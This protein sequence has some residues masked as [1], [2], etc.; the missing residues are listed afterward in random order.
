M[1]F[2]NRIQGEEA[3]ASRDHRAR[4]E[5]CRDQIKAVSPGAPTTRT[6]AGGLEP[7]SR[8]AHEPRPEDGDEASARDRELAAAH[9]AAAMRELARHLRLPAETELDIEVDS[10]SRQVRFL[11]RDRSTGE[12]VRSVPP[13]EAARLADRL[14]E[15]TGVLVDRAL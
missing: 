6:Q 13:E 9:R 1:H 11:I 12:V 7:V 4:A 8:P 15:F 3:P 5:P 14:R 10:E 2:D